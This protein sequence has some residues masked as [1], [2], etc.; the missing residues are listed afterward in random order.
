M[1]NASQEE[2]LRR[3]GNTF[4]AKSSAGPVVCGLRRSALR[5]TG[6]WKALTCTLPHH[7][8]QPE[9]EQHEGD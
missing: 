6:L 2:I 7:K 5:S 1:Q 9:P 4:G 8:Q 3:I